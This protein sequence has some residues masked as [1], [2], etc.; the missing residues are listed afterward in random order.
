VTGAAAAQQSPGPGV[1]DAGLRQRLIVLMGARLVL[2]LVT[3]VVALTLDA[4]VA[5]FTLTERRGFYGTVALA[6]LATVV[7]GLALPHIRRGKAFAAVNIATD[8]AIVSA[9]VQ[10]SGAQDSPFVF[11]YVL[12][13]VYA[14]L[15]FGRVGAM[16]TALAIGVAYA[17]VL[18]GARHGWAGPDTGAAL[19]PRA[20]LLS[21]WVVHAGAVTLVAA[22]SSFL[23]AELQRTGEELARRTSDLRQLQGLYQRTVESLMS[24]LLTTDREGCITSF[25]AEAEKI[26]GLAQSEALGCEVEEVLPGIRATSIDRAAEAVTSSDAR[27]RMPYRNRRGAAYHLG[28]AAYV[29][30][31]DAG[32]PAGHVVIFQDLTRVVEMEAELRR[33][34]RLAAVGELS[35]SIAHEIRNPLAAISGS[36][37]ILRTRLGAGGEGD[38]SRRL[39]DIVLREIDRLNHLIT[40][41]LHF[42]RPSPP[43]RENVLVADAVEAVVEMFRADG[44]SRVEVR[45]RIEPGL[46]ACADP[47]QLRQALWNLVLNGAQAM[48]EGGPL[49][50]SARSLPASQGRPSGGRNGA[51]EG[52][53]VRGVEICIADRGVGIPEEVRERIFDP[54]FTTRPE[55]SGLGLATV[56]RIIERHGGSIRLES[57][58]GGGTRVCLRLPAAEPGA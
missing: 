47:Q 11:L 37:Q 58:S 49:E 24:G 9:L 25:N 6:F 16:A 4:A 7:Y 45:L 8:V 10:L 56:H 44:A 28:V 2:A 39:M 41:F 38:E 32:E 1:E 48:P 17:G 50:I 30:R 31:S 35:A 27:A 12:V 23:A 34:E 13:A 3:L 22:L 57:R 42:A 29:L 18:L 14:A 21:T 20:I 43:A 19:E 52:R 55:G 40:D 15:L 33:S 36:V 46:R 5:D 26:T 51:E 53:K 54:F